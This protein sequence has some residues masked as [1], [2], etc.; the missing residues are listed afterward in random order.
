MAIRVRKDGTMQCAALSEPMAGDTYIDDGLHYQMSVEH[1][2]IM[3]LPMPE[4][5]E[6]PQWWWVNAAPSGCSAIC[7]GP[8]PRNPLRASVRWAARRPDDVERFLAE[9]RETHPDFISIYT[10]GGCYQLHKILRTV[11]PQARPW[12]DL[13]HVWTEIDGAFYDIEGRHLALPKEARPME[14]D[15]VARAHRWHRRTFWRGAAA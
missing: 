10:Q 4:H 7:A 1:G 2:V 3:A 9:L 12:S 15:V 11:W 8:V 13:N 6:N 14:S 5:R